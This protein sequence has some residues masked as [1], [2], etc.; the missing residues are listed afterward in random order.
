MMSAARWAV[1]PLASP[2]RA[3]SS[4]ATAF[5]PCMRCWTARRH[6]TGEE[7]GKLLI[8]ISPG[9]YHEAYFEEAWEAITDLRNVPPN[10]AAPDFQKI[11]AAMQKAG[12]HMVAAAGSGS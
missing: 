6:S 4:S 9:G 7:P 11:G 5:W 8:V 1:R 10:P 3:S 2:P 12:L